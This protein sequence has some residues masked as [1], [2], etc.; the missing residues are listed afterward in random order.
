LLEFFP[1]IGSAR[2]IIFVFFSIGRIPRDMKK[3]GL[4][5]EASRFLFQ[6]RENSQKKSI[7]FGL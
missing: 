2:E 6:S 4:E 7:R 1:T 5:L 3:V